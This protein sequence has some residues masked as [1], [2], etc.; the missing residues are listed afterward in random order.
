MPPGFA[1]LGRP[2]QAQDL[3]PKLLNLPAQGLVFGDQAVDVR[4]DL[5]GPWWRPPA[6]GIKTH[7]G[8]DDGKVHCE[9]TPCA[10]AAPDHRPASTSL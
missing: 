7:P 1:A 5:P 2:A 6:A 4:R 9:A 10:G 8:R 3:L